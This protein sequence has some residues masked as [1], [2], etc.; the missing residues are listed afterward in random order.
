MFSW[1]HYIIH[2]HGFRNKFYQ[3]FYGVFDNQFAAMDAILNGKE[4]F[5]RQVMLWPCRTFSFRSEY[6]VVMI[7]WFL[8]FKDIIC[9]KKSL[10]VQIQVQQLLYLSSFFFC[11]WW[12]GDGWFELIGG[13]NA[14]FILN[15]MSLDG[16]VIIG[17]SIKSVY[18]CGLICHA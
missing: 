15:C 4:S 1:L 8:R 3:V 5:A 12:E 18:H 6:K 9:N 17:N 13:I 16:I 10:S 7:L 2:L 14:I 11:G